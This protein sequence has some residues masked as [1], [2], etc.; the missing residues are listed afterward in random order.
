MLVEHDRIDRVL[1][2]V[3][4]Q[5]AEKYLFKIHERRIGKFQFIEI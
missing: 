1:I 5:R 4:L 3:L 2:R